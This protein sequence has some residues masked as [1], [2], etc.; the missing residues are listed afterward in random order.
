MRIVTAHVLWTILRLNSELI[1]QRMK[2]HVDRQVKERPILFN[3]EMVKAILEGRKTQTRRVVK[4]Q[5]PVTTNVMIQSS[6]REG[7]WWAGNSVSAIPPKVLTGAVS[8]F[9][10][11]KNVSLGQGWK[12]PFGVPGDRL[13]VRETWQYF[14][15]SYTEFGKDFEEADA[16]PKNGDPAKVA[17]AAVDKTSAV[18][19]RP[20]IHMPRWASRITLE[21]TGVRVERVQDISEK[22]AHLEGIPDWK[23]PDQ[24]FSPKIR[25]KE[26]W[27]SIYKNWQ[28]N[29]WVWCVEFRKL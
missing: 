7:L 21:I 28:Q 1:E 2:T 17:Y 15:T 5:P 26:L 12:C 24:T 8:E 27:E 19:W 23:G 20:S 9:T 16:I 13:W 22:D 25:F 14:Q 3:A 10:C 18:W 29:P 11:T 4:P 6:R